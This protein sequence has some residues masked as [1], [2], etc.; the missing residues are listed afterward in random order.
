MVCWLSET[1]RAS[2]S[3]PTEA[4]PARHHR[5]PKPKMH[6]RQ[7]SGQR[8]SSLYS[9]QVPPSPIY[10]IHQLR[11]EFLH[12]PPPTFHQVGGGDKFTGTHFFS[13]SSFL[14]LEGNQRRRVCTW[15]ASAV[16][17]DRLERPHAYAPYLSNFVSLFKK[18]A[19]L[20]KQANRCGNSPRRTID[21]SIR[22]RKRI[23][24]ETVL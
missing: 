24:I 15:A 16:A 2:V 4:R 12:T 14:L 3:Q 1:R 11:F 13:F 22:S 5:R 6:H 7:P 19:S 9:I 23:Q 21:S 8:N 20:G 18:K 17:H 10:A